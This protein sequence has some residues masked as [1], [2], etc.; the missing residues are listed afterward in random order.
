MVRKY[1]VK[2]ITFKK[3]TVFECMP[4]VVQAIWGY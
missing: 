1:D 4:T 3:K 2:L